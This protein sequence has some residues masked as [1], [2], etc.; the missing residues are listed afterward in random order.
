MG[1]KI[2]S[3]N[4]EGLAKHEFNVDLIEYVKHFDIYSFCETWGQNS[5]MFDNFISGFTAFSKVRKKRTKKGRYSGGVSVFVRCGLVDNGCIKRDFVEFNDCVVLVLNGC[6]FGLQNDIVM[7]FPYI[8][9]D[10]ST[11]YNDVNGID[12]FEDYLLQIIMKYP[13]AS[14]LLAG[15]FNARCGSLQDVLVD[16]NVD[17]IFDEDSVYEIDSFQMNRK[18]KDLTHNAFGRSLIELCKSFS[19]HIV[20]G[21]MYQ[22]SDGEIT[23]TANDGSSI[24]DYFIASSNLF[25]NITDF[26]VGDRSE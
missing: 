25:L 10:G 8:S 6:L 24:V 15:D 16:D 17:Y 26:E 18:T 2:G 9:P 11:I 20:N 7:C 19:V 13:D 3:W 4:I 14:L 12:I 21:R 22:D 1:L 23:C 5:T